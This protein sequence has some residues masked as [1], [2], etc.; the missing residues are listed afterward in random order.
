MWCEKPATRYCDAVI[1]VEAR[2]AV[3][4][5]QGG[6]DALLAGLDGEMWTCDAPMCDDHA[7]QV[8][9][10][11]GKEPESID[12]CPHHI[13]HGEEIFKEIV[14][15]KDEAEKKRRNAHAE[16]RRSRIRTERSNEQGNGPLREADG[17]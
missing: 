2:G 13:T 10:I 9:R 17:K 6:V 12:H 8:G 14:M 3:R 7:R 5:K 11:S 15:F 4:N 1:G 16:I